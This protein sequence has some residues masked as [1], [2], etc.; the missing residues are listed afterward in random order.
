MFC[1][2]LNPGKV[3]K[4]GAAIISLILVL[5]VRPAWATTCS[6]S[7]AVSEDLG[8][9]EQVIPGFTDPLHPPISSTTS[10]EWV[11]LRNHPYI[12]LLNGSDQNSGASIQTLKIQ[13]NNLTGPAGVQNMTLFNTNIDI[14]PFAGFDHNIPSINF[15]LTQQHNAQGG[16]GSYLTLTFNNFDPGASI[17]FRLD[18]NPSSSQY[19]QFADYRQVFTKF[20]DGSSTTGN[21][22]STVMF[23]TTDLSNPNPVAGPNAWHNL[24]ANLAG[25]TSFGIAYSCLNSPDT[26]ITLPANSGSTPQVPEPST[27]VL[28]GLGLAGVFLGKTRLLAKGN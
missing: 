11:Y 26:V 25:Q 8:K 1:A 23:K 7:I 19:T 9:L 10:A 20:D 4:V 2:H 21:A 3:R 16:I 18:L 12:A 6:Y 5:A 22:T 24:P 14:Y 15:G 13:L 17:I 28:A 27:L